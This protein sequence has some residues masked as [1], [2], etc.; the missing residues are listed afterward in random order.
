MG[1]LHVC[2]VTAA[3]GVK[4]SDLVQWS[5]EEQYTELACHGHPLV[6]YDAEGLKDVQVADTEA[7]LPPWIPPTQISPNLPTILQ[8]LDEGKEVAFDVETR[9]EA[10]IARLPELDVASVEPATNDPASVDP[11]ATDSTPA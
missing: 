11:A 6:P 10:F 1:K 2:R 8:D 3:T 4:L 7:K 9:L 5:S